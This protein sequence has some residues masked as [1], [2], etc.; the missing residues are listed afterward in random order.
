M[1]FA[2]TLFVS[3]IILVFALSNWFPAVKVL[4]KQNRV[5]VLRNIIAHVRLRSYAIFNRF[6][7]SI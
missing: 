2:F 3:N 4:N 7:T 6:Q 1:I 5:P